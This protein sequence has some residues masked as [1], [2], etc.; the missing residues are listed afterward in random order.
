MKDIYIMNTLILTLILTFNFLLSVEKLFVA[1]EGPFYDG[2][3]S[4]S[5]I[6]QAGN[7]D[8]IENLGNIVQS[9]TIH[10]DHLFVI[11]N[12]SSMIHIFDIDNQTGNLSLNN[13]IDLNFSGPR[14]MLVHEESNTAYITNWN[15]QDIKVMNLE[16]MEIINSIPV[17]GLPED[18]IYDGENIW[19]S[20]TLNADWSDG[21]KVIK[22]NPNDNMITEYEVGYGPGDLLF[23]NNSIYVSRTYYDADWNAYAGTSKIDENGNITLAEYGVGAP[24][25]GSLTT[26]NNIVYRSYNGGIAP[27]NDQLE[28][29]SEQQLGD[30]GFW[31]VY[32]VKSIN[33]K[34][35]FAITDYN[36]LNQVVVLDENGIE[37]ATYDVGLIPTDFAV[38]EST[39]L[40]NNQDILISNFNISNAYPNP[41]NPSTQFDLNVLESGYVSI[42]IFDLNGNLIDVLANDFYTA[43]SYKM[44]WNASN[45]SSGLYIL[46]AQLNDESISQRITLIK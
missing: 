10:N 4:L 22:L 43:G 37:I 29:L 34:I 39:S 15:T 36:T 13:S 38:W 26:H 7:I 45:V 31:N 16:T 19:A 2:Q 24:C 30:L 5:I 3:G 27:L 32:D 1:C 11:S 9:I 46:N 23:H 12:G 40:E 28:L 17:N 42:N 44:D 18:I 20:I 8:E 41:F 21:N 6:D 14:Y 33:N 35:Y 25:G